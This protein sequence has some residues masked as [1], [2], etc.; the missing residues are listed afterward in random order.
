[1]AAVLNLR[2][3]SCLVTGN[4]LN[5]QLQLLLTKQ[6]KF[7][8]ECIKIAIIQLARAVITNIYL[9]L[10]RISESIVNGIWIIIR[11]QLIILRLLLLSC[12][13]LLTC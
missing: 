5:L 12:G 10:E 7:Y 4:Q 8:L 9:A 11:I 13:F 2:E 3:F 1:M 6:L